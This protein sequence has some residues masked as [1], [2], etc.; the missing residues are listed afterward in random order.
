MLKHGRIMC[1][2]I[3]L[4]GGAMGYQAEITEDSCNNFQKSIESL[5]R[6]EQN[7]LLLLKNRGNVFERIEIESPGARVST[8]IYN[9]VIGLVLCWG[10]YINWVLAKNQ[11][12]AALADVYPLLFMGGCFAACIFGVFLFN[13]ST[14]PLLSFLGYNLVVVPLG[15]AINAT[16]QPFVPF[17]V[18]D[19]LRVAVWATLTMTC[20]GVLL[21]RFF[22]KI[23][24]AL[25]ISVLAVVFI[26]AIEI[27]MLQ[28][29]HHVIDLLIALVFCG[30]VGIDWG[31]AN[32]IPKTIPNAVD[33]AAAVYLDIFNLFLR[34]FR[35]PTS[36]NSLY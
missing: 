35:I 12:F 24:R 11:V 34:L 7:G 30:Y 32:R 23:I 14:K 3:T 19:T 1:L 31:R 16:I 2:P 8:Y 33:S 36:K 21:P 9:L 29:Q 18:M 22:E 26:A 4:E 6:K 10:L 28:K 20:F 13:K 27:F 5:K 15:L 25:F 17:L